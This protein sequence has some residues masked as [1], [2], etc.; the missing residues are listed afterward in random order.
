MK[1][2]NLILATSN[3]G[4][5]QEYRRMAPGFAISL[6]LMPDFAKFPAF[7][8]TAPTFAE[9]AAGKALHYSRFTDRVV[10][11]DDSGLVVR[12]L[13]GAPGVRSARYGGQNATDMDRN[14]KLLREMAGKADR[15]ARFV[16]VTALAERG[17]A[18]AVVSDFVRGTITE[19][20]RGPA[21]FGYDP[22]FFVPELGRT[23]GE[24]SAEQ[25]DR[26]SHRGKAF[27]KI[28]AAIGG[29]KLSSIDAAAR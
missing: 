12:A 17:Q 1:I 3:R 7:E 15:E 5:L 6:A 9:N 28:L 23:F 26:L 29:E 25:K 4:K 22:V 24:S 21:G 11:A 13:H 2:D 19:E 27:R 10:L 8:E 14:R 20:I 18:I 16:C